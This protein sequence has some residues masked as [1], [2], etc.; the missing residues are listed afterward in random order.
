[1]QFPFNDWIWKVVTNP[2]YQAVAVVAIVGLAVWTMF[3]TDAIYRGPHVPLLF[4][5]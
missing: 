5:R 1:M 4:G 2:A 3:N